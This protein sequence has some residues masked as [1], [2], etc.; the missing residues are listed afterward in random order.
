[1]SLYIHMPDDEDPKKNKYLFRVSFRDEKTLKIEEM[2]YMGGP[3]L[4]G[5]MTK[6]LKTSRW[7]EKQ[8]RKYCWVAGHIT[9]LYLDN[10]VNPEAE[11]VCEQVEK[12]RMITF[13]RQP[14]KCT[15]TIPTPSSPPQGTHVYLVAF[16][17]VDIS[18]VDR[19]TYLRL[20]AEDVCLAVE[21]THK[22]HNTFT[23]QKI[24]VST[25]EWLHK[26]C[27]LPTEMEIFWQGTTTPGFSQRQPDGGLGHFIGAIHGNMGKGY[28]TALL[29][30]EE[31]VPLEPFLP[32]SCLYDSVNQRVARFLKTLEEIPEEKVETIQTPEV[33]ELLEKLENTVLDIMD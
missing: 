33:L 17:D 24:H 32:K 9:H 1:M 27:L 30:K 3:T 25:H 16:N 5:D 19:S 28:F 10:P 11:D 15:K 4:I 26:S 2:V 6:W 23:V 21:V 29:P 12:A 14:H 22:C 13:S 8:M 20:L 31:F 18:T 7:T